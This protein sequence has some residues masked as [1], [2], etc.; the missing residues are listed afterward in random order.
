[1]SVHYESV[2][3]YYETFVKPARL[4][5]NQHRENPIRQPKCRYIWFNSEK[6]C[7]ST[8]ASM[9]R[10]ESLDD[11]CLGVCLVEFQPATTSDKYQDIRD[12]TVLQL[13][14]PSTST[15]PRAS[16]TLP[17]IIIPAH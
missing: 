4:I 10:S 6:I 12:W 17:S 8:R 14:L 13:Q 3:A 2:P 11:D 9:Q 7:R 1:M 16:V 5:A 15:L